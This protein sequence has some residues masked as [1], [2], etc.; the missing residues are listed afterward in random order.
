MEVVAEWDYLG[1]D[2]M[3]RLLAHIKVVQLKPH[4]F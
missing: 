1:K 4:M 3:V 2:P